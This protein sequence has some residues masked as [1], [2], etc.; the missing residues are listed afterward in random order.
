MGFWLGT[1]LPIAFDAPF[2][3]ITNINQTKILSRFRSGNNLVLIHVAYPKIML[4]VETIMKN[5][6]QEENIVH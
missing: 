5:L 2:E 1:Q 6:P 3:S 4:T